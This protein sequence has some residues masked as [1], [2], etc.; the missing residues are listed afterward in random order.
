MSEMPGSIR[1]CRCECASKWLPC[2]ARHDPNPC[3]RQPLCGLP[4]GLMIVAAY[5]LAICQNLDRRG[6]I[7]ATCVALRCLILLVPPGFRLGENLHIGNK[8]FARQ[9]SWAELIGFRW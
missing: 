5:P 2:I 9:C 7:L 8:Y 1:F 4:H 6:Y 3:F